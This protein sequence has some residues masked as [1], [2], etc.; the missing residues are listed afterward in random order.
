MTLD[1]ITKKVIKKIAQDFINYPQLFTDIVKKI[2]DL[3]EINAPD[4]VLIICWKECLKYGYDTSH[5]KIKIFISNLIEY[6]GFDFKHLYVMLVSNWVL[7]GTLDTL[8]EIKKLFREK[9]KQIPKKESFE[10]ILDYLFRKNLDNG[11][12]HFDLGDYWFFLCQFQSSRNESFVILSDT[13]FRFIKRNGLSA[14]QPQLNQI[15][16]T[17]QKNGIDQNNL[18]PLTRSY[19]KEIS[20][21]SITSSQDQQSENFPLCQSLKMILNTIQVSIEPEMIDDG[22]YGWIFKGEDCLKNPVAIKIFK[23]SINEVNF[24][25]YKRE[26]SIPNNLNHPNIIRMKVPFFFTFEETKNFAYIMDY[27]D[28]N[29]LEDLFPIITNHDFEKKKQYIFEILDAL[30]YINEKM[31]QHYD[32]H[33]RNVMITKQY[34]IQII[35][36]GGTFT[37]ASENLKSNHDNM[38]KIS[39]WINKIFSDDEKLLLN[40]PNMQDN[41]NLREWRKFFT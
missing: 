20:E 27:I 8:S 15:Y 2:E 17:F 23:E 14:S 11:F 1:Q 35:D 13:L 4:E 21:L 16:S 37:N 9:M 12:S 28:G 38:K 5:P 40:L 26:Y 18:D 6:E 3:C 31:E 30:I 33:P 19:F 7:F 34:Q 24:D 29:T 39:E 22:T 10:E 25:D 32:L 41:R 36:I